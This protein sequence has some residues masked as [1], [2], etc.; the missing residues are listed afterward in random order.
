MP[1]DLESLVVWLLAALVGAIVVVPYAWTFHRRRRADRARLAEARDLG[2]DKPASQFPFIDSIH[3]IGCGAC[4]RACPEGDVLGVVGGIAVVINGVRCV[5]HGRCADACPVDAIEIGMGD[6]KGRRDVPRLTDEMETSVSGVFIAGELSGLA[7]IRNAIEQGQTVVRTV[8]AR[9]RSRAA[10]PRPQGELD[11]LIVGAGPAGVSAALAAR[12]AGLSHLVIDQADGLGGTILHFPRRK[13]VLTRPVELPGG[14]ALRREE[15]TKEELLELLEEQIEQRRLAVRF[16]ERLESIDRLDDALSVRTSGG[17]HRARHVLLALGRRGTPRKLGVPGEELSKVMYQLRDAETYRGRKVLVVGGGDSA[18]EAAIGLARQAGTDVTLSYR[19][20]G[21]FRIKQ[22]NQTSAESLIARGRIRALFGSEVDSIEED[23]V[24][25]RIGDQRRTLPNDDVFVFIGGEPPYRL[26]ERCG[27]RF[28]GDHGGDADAGSERPSAPGRAGAVA[29][30]LLA[31]LLAL[32]TAA[33]AQDSP[34]GDSVTTCQDCHSTADWSVVRTDLKFDHSGTGFDLVG[35]HASLNCGD[36]HERTDFSHVPTACADCH[37]DAH[38]GELGIACADCHDTKSWDVRRDFRT[39]HQRTLFA[40]I[41]GHARVDCE[42]CHAAAPPRQFTLVPTDCIACHRADFEGADTPA[43]FG[44]ITDCQSCHLGGS[45]SWQRTNFVHPARFPLTGGHASLDC[46][47]CHR[48]GAASTSTDCYA[49]HRAD[50]ESTREPDHVRA[51]FPT[52]CVLCHSITSFTSGV[53]NHLTTGFALTGAHVTTDCASCHVGGRY[54]GTPR[55]CVACHRG[56]YDATREPNH[57]Q[58][59]FPLACEQCHTTTTF[60]GAAFDHALTGFALTGAHRSIDCQ[61]CHAGGR[62]AGTPTAC[63]DCHRS[64]YDATSDPNHASAGFPTTCQNCH[65]TSSWEGAAFD[66]STSAFPLTGAHRNLDCQAC[67]SGGFAGTPT[68]CVDCHRADYDATNDPNHA[69]AG[70]STNCQDCH[71]T[72]SW[73]GATFDHDASFFPIN[74]GRH[75]GTWSACSD[76]HNVAGNFAVF[77]CFTCHGRNQ[78]DSHHTG[79]SGY[80]YESTACYSCH[81]DGR[82]EDD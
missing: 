57:A 74:S 31:G 71:S 15:Y 56:D 42:G 37:R 43:H 78:T 6:L 73:E 53:F 14:A 64:E 10:G 2:I 25:L 39:M 67:H 35:A 21:L 30:A 80:V 63:V 62:F 26:L 20:P 47:D 66:H 5:G 13:M 60:F 19:K 49:C 24:T 29:G 28:G 3:C 36:C 11:L 41:A 76:C 65:S 70:F 75:R 27:V 16:G 18:V 38:S 82:A 12:E 48:Q 4:A 54:A 51:G 50:F 1:T 44:A 22:K 17:E 7:L 33:A 23:R 9:C 68:A 61:Q 46:A 40:L 55:D 77:T 72:T 8:A 52:N 81:P 32:A 59:G 45:E 34:H 58:A 69:S 79:V